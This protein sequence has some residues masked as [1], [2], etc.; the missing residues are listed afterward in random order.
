MNSKVAAS[1]SGFVATA[2]MTAVMVG[3]HRL[4]PG[5][6]DSPLPPRQITENAAEA[7]GVADQMDEPEREGATLAAHFGYGATA[8]LGYVPFVGS[9][10]L[11]PAAEGALYGL[12]VW[13]GSY[14]GL[15]PATGLYR[16]AT[17][18]PAARNALMIAAHLVWGAALGITFARLT[19]NRH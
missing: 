15:M 17:D 12:A 13:G 19:R 6:P 7:T 5:E 10:G 11:P 1:I 14:L 8:A 3:L 2:P 9:S 18:E 16:S 4:L